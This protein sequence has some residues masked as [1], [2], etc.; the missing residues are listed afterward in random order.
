MNEIYDRPCKGVVTIGYRNSVSGVFTPILRQ[1]NLVMYEAADAMARLCAGDSRYAISHM[2]Y[3]YENTNSSPSTVTFG[4]QDG[5]KTYLAINTISSTT[6]DWLRIPIYTK[7]KIDTYFA[8]GEDPLIYA[9][10]MA[11]FVATSAAYPTNAGGAQVG[12]S[13]QQNYFASSGTNGASKV[14][15][16]ALA[17]SPDPN[18]K[19]KDLVF[20]RLA[21]QTPIVVQSNSYID[22]FWSLAFK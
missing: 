8:T 18:D 17:V 6:V 15:C 7:A 14:T 3:Q 1:E 20:S 12:Q 9:A 13:P 10:N 2:Y 16:V 22:C 11:T 5:I 19:A 4:R 21:L